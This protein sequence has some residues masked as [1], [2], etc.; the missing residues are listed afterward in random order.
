MALSSYHIRQS[1]NALRKAL[2]QYSAKFT[3]RVPWTLNFQQQPTE[4]ELL[5][6]YTL[7][8]STECRTI[9][10]QPPPQRRTISNMNGS[11]CIAILMFLSAATAVVRCSPATRP[12]RLTVPYP[13][14]SCDARDAVQL[15]RAHP[16]DCN[17]FMYCLQGRYFVTECP[18][19]YRWNTVA[20]RCFDPHAVP[21]RPTP[22][23]TWETT[24]TAGTTTTTTTTESDADADVAERPDSSSDDGELTNASG[25]DEL[26]LVTVDLEE[27]AKP[28]LSATKLPR[29]GNNMNFVL[30]I[31]QHSKK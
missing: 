8:P 14:D 25:T 26:E 12:T 4:R 10:R 28:L 27:L 24:T 13:G 31:S 15:F 17:K 5:G 23:T 2:R 18:P 22:P 30:N 20:Q 9:N 11:N 29:I 1:R 16:T 19:F 21:E 3:Y 6:I 7:S